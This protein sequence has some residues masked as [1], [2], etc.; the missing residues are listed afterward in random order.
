MPIL[1]GYT[2]HHTLAQAPNYGNGEYNIVQI[3]ILNSNAIVRPDNAFSD[4]V[5]SECICQQCS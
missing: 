2:G 3:T 4:Y 5:I 1:K